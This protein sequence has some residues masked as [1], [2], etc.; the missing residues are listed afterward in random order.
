VPNKNREHIKIREEIGKM[1]YDCGLTEEQ[2]SKA[3]GIPVGVTIKG[4]V[5]GGKGYS[6]QKYSVKWYILCYN[7]IKGGKTGGTKGIEKRKQNPEKYHEEMVEAGKIGGKKTQ[8]LHPNIMLENREKTIKITPNY[9]SEAGKMGAKKTLER[10]PDHMK[11]MNRRCNELQKL[12]KLTNPE[13][14]KKNMNLRLKKSNLT[15]KKKDPIGYHLHHSKNATKILKILRQNK[16]YYFMGV[17]FDSKSEMKV[18]EWLNKNLGFIPQ[19]GVNCH[20]RLDGGE[21]DFKLGETFLEYH[22]CENFYHPETYEEYC[23]KRRNI[24]DNNGFKDNKLIVIDNIEKLNK[25]RC[26]YVK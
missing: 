1:Y 9:L 26:E 14:Y 13:E 7:S 6:F 16:P 15:W 23:T 8:K 10:N 24:L 17:P 21:V 11:Y 22:P 5:K 2:I 25:I 3:L 18:A 19:E 12:F 4:S 20:V